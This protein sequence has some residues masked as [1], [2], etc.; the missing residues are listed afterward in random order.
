MVQPGSLSRA[1]L[2]PEYESKLDSTEVR[3]RIARGIAEGL[4]YIHVHDI[5]HGAL[6]ADSVWLDENNTPKLTDIALAQYLQPARARTIAPTRW[7]APEL[8][9]ETNTSIAPKRTTTTDVWALGIT[10]LE[11]YSG[12]EQPFVNFVDDAVL[13]KFVLHQRGTPDRP[14][15]CPPPDW[16]CIRPCFAFRPEDRCSVLGVLADYDRLSRTARS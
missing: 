13:T 4:H 14:D 5:V 8:L 9:A 11:L 10:L 2:D 3:R 7:W 12:G 16:D 6:C 1:L 15:R